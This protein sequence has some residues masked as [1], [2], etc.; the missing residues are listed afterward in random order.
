MP[1]EL[2]FCKNMLGWKLTFLTFIRFHESP[3]SSIYSRIIGRN[4]P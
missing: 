1:Q 4:A 2:R 3:L